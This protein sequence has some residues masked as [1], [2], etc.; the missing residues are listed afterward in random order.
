MGQML[1]MWFYA[2]KYNLTIF[3]YNTINPRYVESQD[4]QKKV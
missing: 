2:F 4:Q 1:G 3:L